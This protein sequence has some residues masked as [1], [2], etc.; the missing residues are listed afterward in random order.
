MRMYLIGK[1]KNGKALLIIG[2]LLLGKK[3]KKELMV[4]SKK[5]KVRRIL[6]L[7][8]LEWNQ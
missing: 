3:M 4:V 5:E 8:T 1:L 7:I 6:F 2:L